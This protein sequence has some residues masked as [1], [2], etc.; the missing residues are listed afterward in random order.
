M[1]LEQIAVLLV[2][3]SGF[4]VGHILAKYTKDEI[5]DKTGRKYFKILRSLSLGTVIL[6]LLFYSKDALILILPIVLIT[7]LLA[8]TIKITNKR[9]EYLSYLLLFLTLILVFVIKNTTLEFLLGSLIFIFL[10]SS[11]AVLRGNK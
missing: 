2:A 1:I 6:S 3:F 7:F 10:L 11:V 4:L 9:R 8:F 5:R